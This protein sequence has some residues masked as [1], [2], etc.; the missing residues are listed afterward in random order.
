MHFSE[1]PLPKKVNIGDEVINNSIFGF[2][3]AYNTKFMWLTNLLNKK[4]LQSMPRHRP[5]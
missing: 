3:V 4:F 2:N 5:R 1:K